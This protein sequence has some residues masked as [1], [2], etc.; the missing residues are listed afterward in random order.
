MEFHPVGSF[1]YA[2]I[3]PQKNFSVSASFSSLE[4]VFFVYFFIYNGGCFF[5]VFFT[6]FLCI[7]HVFFRISYRFKY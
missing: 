3:P 7:F 1:F 4:E 5:S 2:F 6:Y